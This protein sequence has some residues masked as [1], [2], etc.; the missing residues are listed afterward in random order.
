VC[1]GGSPTASAETG[2]LWM[3]WAG[4]LAPLALASEFGRAGYLLGDAD[5]VFGSH[6]G[7]VPVQYRLHQTGVHRA[8][9]TGLH[10]VRC[11]SST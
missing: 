2:H 7:V 11:S 3:T 8:G 1:K 6:V 9:D 5:V 10:A 4:A